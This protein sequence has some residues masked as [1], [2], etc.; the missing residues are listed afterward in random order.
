MMNSTILNN[1][2]TSYFWSFFDLILMTVFTSLSI[3]RGDATVFY[4][5]YLF[6]WYEFLNIAV[7]Q[8]FDK[9]YKRTNPQSIPSIHKI[10]PLFMMFIYLILIIVFFGIIANWRN[11]DL[12]AINVETLFFKSF[13]FNLNLLFIFVELVIKNLR[14]KNNLA[15]TYGL[16]G[17]MIVL[18]ISIILG[19]IMLFFVV[20]QFPEIFSP[21]QFFA[22]LLILFPFLLLRFVAQ[23]LQIKKK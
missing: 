1:K 6:W 9:V 7:N 22:S 12:I 15:V 10:G 21:D 13:Y 19:A 20:N 8:I 14:A 5:L 23:Y 11:Y 2:S 18:H 3:Y 4:V 17:N 16:S